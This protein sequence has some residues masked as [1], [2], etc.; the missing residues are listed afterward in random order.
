MKETTDDSKTKFFEWFCKDVENFFNTYWIFAVFFITELKDSPEII[1]EEIKINIPK[2]IIQYQKQTDNKA[3]EPEP[4]DEF[5]VEILEALKK[6]F[7]ILI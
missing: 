3:F 4:S 7:L 1:L 6:H 2:K 5:C